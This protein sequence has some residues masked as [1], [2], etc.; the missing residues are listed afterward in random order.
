VRLLARLDRRGALRFA[1]LDGATAAPWRALAGP[2]GAAPES[3]VVV[4][5]AGDAHVGAAA[6][7]AAL[8]ACGG[9]AGLAGR[10]LGALPQALSDPVYRAVSRRRTRAGRCLLPAG[11]ARFLP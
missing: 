10:A 5:S 8:R 11:D 9:A 2:A 1:P 3:L 4:D 7:A 6:T